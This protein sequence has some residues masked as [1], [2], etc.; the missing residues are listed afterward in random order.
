MVV[1]KGNR[2]K[3]DFGWGFKV[4]KLPEFCRTFNIFN[5]CVQFAIQG[6]YGYIRGGISKQVFY[7]TPF[8]V[9]GKG[10]F[11]EFEGKTYKIEEFEPAQPPMHPCCVVTKWKEV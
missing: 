8:L 11:F 7:I 4:P 6:S 5:F 2:C 3:E 10:T 9:G 1:E